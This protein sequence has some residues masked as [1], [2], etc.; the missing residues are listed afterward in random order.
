MASKGQSQEDSGKTKLSQCISD[1]MP[2]L[3]RV[4]WRWNIETQRVYTGADRT[5]R[6]SRD[7]SLAC[8][9]VIQLLTLRWPSMTD[10]SVLR[11]WQSTKGQLKGNLS[12]PFYYFPGVSCRNLP[13]TQSGMFSSMDTPAIFMSQNHISL[14]PLVN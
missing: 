10:G 5:E 13:K 7:L 9:T 4:L 14:S 11:G 8:H 6:L 12:K 3:N 2:S 1:S